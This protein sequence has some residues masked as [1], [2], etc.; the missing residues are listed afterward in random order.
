MKQ[1]IKNGIANAKRCNI[2]KLVLCLFVFGLNVYKV[3]SV[4]LNRYFYTAVQ[5][6]VEPVDVSEVI[7]SKDKIIEQKYFADGDILNSVRLYPKNVEYQSDDKLYIEVSDAFGVV[8]NTGILL[9][10]I[11]CDRWN[12]VDVSCNNLKIGDEYILKI[13]TGESAAQV[14]LLTDL[15]GS[16]SDAFGSCAVSGNTIDGRLVVGTVSALTFNNVI[17]LFAVIIFA[18]MAIVTLP[19]CYV[20]F[21]FKAIKDNYFSTDRKKNLIMSVF[22]ALTFSLIYIPVYPGENT[23]TE[24]S[25]VIGQATVADFDVS[26]FIVNFT[27]WLAVLALSFVSFHML[28]CYYVGKSRSEEHRKAFDFLHKLCAVGLVVIVFKYKHF[29]SETVWEQGNVYSLFTIYLIGAAIIAYILFDLDRKIIFDK[30]VQ[31]VFVGLLLSFPL[32]FM[33]S[34]IFFKNNNS[35][36]SLIIFCFV[37]TVLIIAAFCVL[38]KKVFNKNSICICDSLV[39][40]FSA[41]PFITSVYIEMINILNQRGIFIGKPLRNYVLVILFILILSIASGIFLIKKNRTITFDIKKYMYPM[42]LLG[43]AFISVQLPL[44]ITKGY[45]IFES[46]NYSVLITDFLNFGKIPIVEHYGGHMLTDVVSGIMYGWIN[47]DVIGAAFSPYAVYI[48]PILVLIF[49]C[50]LKNLLDEDYAFFISLLFP[51]MDTYIYWS[52]FGLGMIVALA[53]I[54]YNKKNTWIRAEIIWI[55]CVIAVLYRL[56]LGAAYGIAAVVTL[57][58]LS[59]KT[60]DKKSIKQLFITLAATIAAVGV[61]WFVICFAKGINPVTR[62]VE[63]IVISASNQTWGRATIGDTNNFIFLLTYLILPFS[64]ICITVYCLFISKRFSGKL[65]AQSIILYVLAFS[66]FA[67]FSRSLVRH[68]MVEMTQQCM[69]WTGWLF[70]ACFFAVNFKKKSLFLPVFAFAIVCNAAV[71][72]PNGV[73]SSSVIDTASLKISNINESWFTEDD[74]TTYWEDI[75]KDKTIVQRVK[76]PDELQQRIDNYNMVFDLLL[77]D[78]ETYVDF[79]NY[80]FLYSVLNRYDPVYVSQSP[81]HLS[82][83]FSQMQFISD[84]EKNNVPIAIMPMNISFSYSK[85]LDGIMNNFRYYKVAEYIYENYRPLCYL[86]DS[87]IWCLNDRYESYIE[88]LKLPAEKFDLNRFNTLDGHNC[89]IDNNDGVISIT[90]TGTDPSVYRFHNLFEAFPREDAGLNISLFSDKSGTIQ[91]YYTTEPDERFSEE[92][93]VKISVIAGERTVSMKIPFNEYTQLRFDIPDDSCVQIYHMYMT[94]T[95]VADYGYDD[96]IHS[97]NINKLPLIWAERDKKGAS[98]NQVLSDT[99]KNDS[100]VYVFTDVESA[101]MSHDNGKYLLVSVDYPGNDTAGFTGNDDE[102][103]N[104][105]LR[106]GVLNEKFVSMYSYS[107]TVQEGKHDYIFRVSSDYYWNVANINSAVIECGSNIYNVKMCVLEGD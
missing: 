73:T 20:I 78:N 72:D 92:K 91:M 75:K 34:G 4:D 80:T 103:C 16:Y 63:F 55:M 22:G 13:Y 100:G 41:V 9:S 82:G 59:L 98:Q 96:K 6:S 69:Y 42:F 83:E 44:V 27:L 8:F 11:V 50:M 39:I 84:I 33:S 21:N 79:V 67:N 107:F 26:R 65:N 86:N 1:M 74:G 102:S 36:F 77:E 70:L 28:L 10:D 38:P 5:S 43:I 18:G 90:A 57:V 29:F 35:V 31:V 76:Y 30:Y 104:A 87:A 93:S 85:S 52:Y 23:I 12:T 49:Y 61:A 14:T 66:Y 95:P 94:S 101:H 7:C 3:F 54:N 62:L 64:I 106:M 99:V 19:V 89:K 71:K 45:D 81:G 40:F 97:Y 88:R 25:R 46:A 32:S 15:S 68:S 48:N 53:I 56:D 58:L 17:I 105:V 47:Q 24:F 60:K 37:F 2:V 51:F